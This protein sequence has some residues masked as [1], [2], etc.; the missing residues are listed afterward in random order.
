[1]LKKTISRPTTASPEHCPLRYWPLSQP[2]GGNDRLGSIRAEHSAR[3][4]AQPVGGTA[5]GSGNLAAKDPGSAQAIAEDLSVE[6]RPK[7][8][9]DRTSFTVS[10]VSRQ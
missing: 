1:M 5:G 10:A 9:M 2:D 3:L 8:R 4:F 7:L 6:L